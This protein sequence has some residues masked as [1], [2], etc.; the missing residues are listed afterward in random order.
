[1][2][3]NR[4]RKVS[5]VDV[6]GVQNLHV[7][8]PLANGHREVVDILA[9]SDAAVFLPPKSKFFHSP[10]AA[11]VVDR[12]M[13]VFLCLGEAFV[14]HDGAP[15]FSEATVRATASSLSISLMASAS[16]TSSRAVAGT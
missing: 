6:G 12:R 11:G 10:D 16:S 4:P 7:N 2:V 9:A 1:T 8:P 14:L 13:A 15:F 5:E 3:P